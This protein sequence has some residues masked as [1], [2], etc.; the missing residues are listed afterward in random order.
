MRRPSD[1]GLL[2][3]DRSIAADSKLKSAGQ[4]IVEEVQLTTVLVVIG[5]PRASLKNPE[6]DARLFSLVE[7]IASR[8]MVKQDMS[9]AGYTDIAITLAIRTLLRRGF[10][11]EYDT[12]DERGN[13]YVCI[14]A[15]D[16][17]LEWLETNQD[18]IVFR[19]EPKST[20]GGDDDLPF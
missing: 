11:T 7:H 3:L 6:L 20:K 16:T 14:D 8:W 15:T 9:R 1:S 18:R 4:V 19:Q 12:L 10:V 5:E 2:A 13:E 17:G